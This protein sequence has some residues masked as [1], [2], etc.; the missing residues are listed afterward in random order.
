MNTT[1]MPDMDFELAC[2]CLVAS[3]HGGWDFD[4]SDLSGCTEGHTFSEAVALVA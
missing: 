2:G 3:N 1:Q 4:L